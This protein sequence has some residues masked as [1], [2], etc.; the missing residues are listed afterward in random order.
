MSFRYPFLVAILFLPLITKAQWNTGGDIDAP[1]VHFGFQLGANANTF[2]VIKQPKFQDYQISSAGLGGDVSSGRLQV[3]QSQF[4]TG[5]HLGL[6]GNL[7][8]NDNLDLRFTPDV[9]FC[10][11]VLQYGYQS[12]STS[13]PSRYNNPVTKTISSTFV[14]FPL[15]MKFKSD[16]KGNMRAYII[17]GLQYS[18]DIVP[19]K[20]T[21][22]TGLDPVNKLVK[23]KSDLLS[24]KVGFGVDLYYEYFK[25]SPELSI[26]NSLF[27]SLDKTAIN[28]F[29]GPLSRLYPTAI[30]LTLYFE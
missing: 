18:H 13:N 21:D 22:D 6:V 27:N 3:I 23:I 28:Q 1:L 20:K 25:M 9:N 11:R 15:L 7:R 2:T 16:R 14:D 24:Y 10:D 8:L 4:T 30:M 12:L 19:K 29:N 17:G 26:T 5:F